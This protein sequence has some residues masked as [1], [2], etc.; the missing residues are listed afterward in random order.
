MIVLRAIRAQHKSL[1]AVRRSN[2]HVVVLDQSLPPLVRRRSRSLETIQLRRFNAVIITQPTSFA[3]HWLCAFVTLQI[4]PPPLL[5]RHKLHRRTV[6]DKLHAS[7]RKRLC[8]ELGMRRTVQRSSKPGM[9]K[10]RL[11]RCTVCIGDHKLMP[12]GHGSAV[13]HC[14]LSFNPGRHI[15]NILC[16]LAILRRQPCGASVVGL[17]HL[18]LPHTGKHH[19]HHG[20]L[21]PE[22]DVARH[23]SLLAVCDNE[24]LRITNTSYGCVGCSP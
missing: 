3:V 18:R 8:L 9:I 4:A 6:I 24:S 7:K 21:T 13:Y 1:L 17:R 12:T 2:H 14:L 5:L 19:G 10:R 15:G 23:T 22:S 20:D 16:Q 11:F